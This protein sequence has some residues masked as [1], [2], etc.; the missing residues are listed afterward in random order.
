M[1]YTILVIGQNY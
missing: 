1:Q